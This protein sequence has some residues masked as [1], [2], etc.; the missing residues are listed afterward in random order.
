MNA[1][2]TNGSCERCPAEMGAE[3]LLHVHIC[4][5]G[6]D[7]DPIAVT[8]VLSDTS[9]PNPKVE[10]DMTFK[11]KNKAL[12]AI[13]TVGRFIIMFCIYVGFLC[14]IKLTF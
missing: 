5:A 13:Q 3:L 2:V 8:L 7:V 9:V 11:V 10:E 1:C 12:G 14:V 6:A 4:D